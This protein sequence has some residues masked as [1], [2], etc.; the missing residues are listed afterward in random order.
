MFERF[1]DHARTIFRNANNLAIALG[2]GTIKPKHILL[3]IMQFKQGIAPFAL[4]E[5]AGAETLA[6]ERLILG[7]GD[8]PHIRTG[9]IMLDLSPEA[10]K[11]IELAKSESKAVNNLYIGTEHILLALTMDEELSSTF[12][13]INVTGD[14]LRTQIANLLDGIS[15][16]PLAQTEKT[17]VLNMISDMAATIKFIRRLLDENDLGRFTSH[18]VRTAALDTLNIQDK[19]WSAISLADRPAAYQPAS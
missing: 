7:Q 10:E 11:T 2:S 4:A 17:S 5:C 6:A 12:Q 16:V 3:A 18:E 8:N 9:Q 13:R 14:K 1:S 19:E 15:T